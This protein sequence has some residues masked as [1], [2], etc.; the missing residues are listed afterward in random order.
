MPQ[1]GVSVAEG[2]VVEWEAARRLGGGRR[3]DLQVSTD[4]IDIE[5]PS[6]AAGRVTE[7]AR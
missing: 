1:M 4:K 3:D 5:V 6:P 7:V 2:T